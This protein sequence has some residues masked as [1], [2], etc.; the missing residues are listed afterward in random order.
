MSTRKKT[1]K[2]KY[3]P[4]N[5]ID[6]NGVIII[7]RFDVVKDDDP[8]EMIFFNISRLFNGKGLR[9]ADPDFSVS[10]DFRNKVGKLLDVPSMD[11]LIKD[12]ERLYTNELDSLCLRNT[13]QL[14]YDIL[15]GRSVKGEGAIQWERADFD[16]IIAH[17][18]MLYDSTLTK[19]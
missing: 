5:D 19:Q 16:K 14:S 6:K 18:R 17:L 7:T 9:D 4:F 8:T 12:I 3:Y 1:P 10:Y 15:A 11:N 2:N 13:P